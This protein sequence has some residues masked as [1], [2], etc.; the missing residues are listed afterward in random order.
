MDFFTNPHPMTRFAFYTY[1]LGETSESGPVYFGVASSG[2]ESDA[3]RWD[4]QAVL[5]EVIR[6]LQIPKSQVPELWHLE[7]LED[8]QDQDQRVAHTIKRS[9][10]YQRGDAARH[11]QHLPTF[12]YSEALPLGDQ[13][14][15]V[16]VWFYPFAFPS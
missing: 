5:R 13:E 15:S 11:H 4:Q 2:K 10:E 9:H 1:H 3:I 8:P 7:V 14:P 6:L 16:L 12:F